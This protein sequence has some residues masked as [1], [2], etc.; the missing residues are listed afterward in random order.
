MTES[1]NDETGPSDTLPPSEA[2]DSDEVANVDGDEVVDP[3][4]DWQ[5]ADEPPGPSE[6]L[7][8]KLD[9]EE[10]DVTSDEPPRRDVNERV[11]EAEDVEVVHPDDTRD[12]PDDGDSLFPV[13]R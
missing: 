3:P 10:P 6:S 8:R 13:V 5:A 9:A 12:E 11:A 1:S 7:D 2:T 4:E